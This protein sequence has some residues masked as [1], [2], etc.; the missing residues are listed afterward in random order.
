MKICSNNNSVKCYEYFIND[1]YFIIIME[2]CDE[3]LSKL[4]NERFKKYNK[5]FNPE[6][7]FEIMKQLNNA[8]KIMK[9]NNIIHRNLKLEN[10]L[11]KY[12]DK[13][14]KNFTIKLSGY[15]YSKRL[16]SLSQYCKSFVGTIIYMAPEI[17]KLKEGEEYNYKC[18]LWSIGIIIY[19]LL[20]LKSPFP[21][22]EE[23]A[24]IKNIDKLGNKILK[25]TGNEEL[26]D[27]IKKLLEK[28]PSKR[29]DWDKYLNHPFFNRFRNNINIIYE[30][31]EDGI[32]NI[33]GEKFVENNKNN[34]ELKINGIKIKLVEKYNLKKGIN[35]IEMIIKNKLNNLEYMFDR[36]KSLKNIEEL[37]YLN[38][39]EVNNFSHMIKYCISLSDIKGLEKWNVSNGNNFS[40][41]FSCCQSL[42]NIKGLEKW[43]VSNGKYFS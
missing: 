12:N 1:E 26:D 27:L 18:D 23:E 28:E 3:N 4:L 16:E 10:I 14:H 42:S 37:K 15:G 41:M 38:T 20:Y 8:F 33:F 35:K 21:G 2:L 22:E 30:V 17:L 7:I 13:E 19:R 9:E 24:I 43:N 29:L 25:K 31:Y 40:E 32:E 34:I 36:C 6:E 39:K 5:G 11:I